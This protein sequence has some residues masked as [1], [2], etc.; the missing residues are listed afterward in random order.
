MED[1]G[2]R[3]SSRSAP[4]AVPLV[5]V[6]TAVP[7]IIDLLLGLS[8]PLLVTARL[9]LSAGLLRG[10]RGFRPLLRVVSCCSAIGAILYAGAAKGAWLV[11]GAE[12]IAALYVV[13]ALG[14]EPVRGW[15]PDPPAELP[16]GALY[17][18]EGES[19]PGGIRG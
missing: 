12:F 3:R 8:I 6:A 19:A 14:T 16:E 17:P 18:G 1:G 13:V 15:C 7:A 9:V 11:A 10:V 2:A 4:A 5:V